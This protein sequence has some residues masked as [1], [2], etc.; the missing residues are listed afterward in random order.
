MH[1]PKKSEHETESFQTSYKLQLEKR[2]SLSPMHQVNERIHR[3][4]GTCK[5]QPLFDN[6]SINLK[7][8]QEMQLLNEK[9]LRVKRAIDTYQEE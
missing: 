4:I 3:I 7:H 9:Q 5:D 6:D 8:D 2:L 1:S